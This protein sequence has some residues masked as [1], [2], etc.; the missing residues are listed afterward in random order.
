MIERKKWEALDAYI[1]RHLITPD[2][3]LVQAIESSIE[4]EMPQIQVAEVQ[5][6]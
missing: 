3:T 1:G 4:A 5:G 6:K 2:A